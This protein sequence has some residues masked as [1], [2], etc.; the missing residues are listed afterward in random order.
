MGDIAGRR[1]NNEFLAKRPSYLYTVRDFYLRSVIVKRGCPSISIYKKA[2]EDR[3]GHTLKLSVWI[4][5]KRV[6]SKNQQIAIIYGGGGEG[7]GESG[8][9]LHK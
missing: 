4:F 9:L 1:S 7:G 2:N 3:G 6:G 8:G 5:S